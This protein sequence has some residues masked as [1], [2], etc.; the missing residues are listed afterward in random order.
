MFENVAVVEVALKVEMVADRGV[1]GGE[2]LKGLDVPE[3]RH[4]SFPSS[5][6]LM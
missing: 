1:N 2:F 4:C 5:K 3:F 6:R